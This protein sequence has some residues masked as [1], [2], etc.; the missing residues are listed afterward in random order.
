MEVFVLEGEGQ[1]LGFYAL[2]PCGDEAELT[3]LFVE[4]S[5]IGCGFGRAFCGYLVCA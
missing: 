4:P 5:A 1:I 3:H 2:R